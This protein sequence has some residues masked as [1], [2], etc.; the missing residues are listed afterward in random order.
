M[1]NVRISISR[2]TVNTL[3]EK[4]Q[5][6]YRAGDASLVKRVTAL[7]RISRHEPA[8]AICQELGGSLSSVYHWLRKLMYDGVNGLEVRWRGGRHRKLTKTQKARLCALLKAGSLAAGF[9]SAC[10]NA[11]LIQELIA[12]EFGVLYN[13]Q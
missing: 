12:R 8:E 6:A 5:Q 2:E 13:V 9:T 1:L 11:A 4:L 10:W 3:Q 7:L